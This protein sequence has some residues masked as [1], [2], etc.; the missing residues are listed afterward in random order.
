MFGRVIM[1]VGLMALAFGCEKSEMSEA[2]KAEPAAAAKAEITDDGS[3]QR[4]EG[5][6]DRG[7]AALGGVRPGARTSGG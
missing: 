7:Q 6:G 4:A 5:L 3:A 2:A 1:V